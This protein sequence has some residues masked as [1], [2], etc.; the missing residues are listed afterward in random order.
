MGGILCRAS[1][2]NILASESIEVKS[3][4]ENL[5]H[6]WSCALSQW[7]PAILAAVTDFVEDNFSTNWKV[8]GMVWGWFKYSTYI[9]HFISIIIT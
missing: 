2:K 8:G 4:N 9:V 6:S 5:W 7:S 3:G 1:G